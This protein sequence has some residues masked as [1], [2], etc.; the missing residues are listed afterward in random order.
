MKVQRS[1]NSKRR[2]DAEFK[3]EAVRLADTSGKTNRQIERDLGLYQGAIGRWRKELEAD[4]MDAFPG[5]GHQKPLEE[6]NRQLRRE[7]DGMREERDI[8]KKSGGHLLKGTESRFM[9]IKEHRKEF[10]VEKMA[11]VLDVSKSGYYVWLSSHGRYGSLKIA[12]Q[13]AAQGNPYSH[14]R[15][16]DSM[17]RQG[18]RSKVRRK[19]VVTT[20]T[21]HNLKASPNLLNRDLDVDCPNNVWSS[22][23]TYLRS[24]AGW[25]FL[26]VFLDLF[27]RRVVG[28]C[29]ST[30]IGTRNGAQG[31]LPRSMATQAGTWAD[32]PLRSGHPV[33]LRRL[34]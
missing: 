7:L 3:K 6:E 28:W 18:L 24:R 32:D 5:T 17:R 27:S 8:L 11:K 23:I 22:D 1:S 15:V 21:K 25:L 20:D 2:Y 12:R 4:P 10:S 29:V 26:V 9:F 13:L 33:L 34:P 30:S 19:F 31:L 14:S 16:A